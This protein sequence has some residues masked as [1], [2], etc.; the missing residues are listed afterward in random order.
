MSNVATGQTKETTSD[1]AGYYSMPNMLEGK[2]NLTVK[3]SGFRPHTETNIEVSI[4]TVT[5][6]N[7]GL[8][9]GGVT[10]SVTVEASAAILQT[11]KAD[12]NVSLESRAMENLPLSNFRNYQTLINLVPG[13]TPA[14]FQNA[15]ADTPGRS[16][17]TNIN[18]QQRGANNTRLDGSADILVTMPHH[19]V[20]V[21]PVESIAEV[22]ISTNS[23]DAEQGM[24]GGAAVTVVTKSGTNDFHGSLFA[25]HNNSATRAFLWDE[26]R[27]RVAKKPKN[28]LNIDGGSI[29]G[30]IKKNKLFFFADWEGTF[31]RS[32]RF[33]L[34]SVPTA[35]LRTGDFTRVFGDT[36]PMIFDPYTGI[37]DGSG[38][39]PFSYLGKFNVIPPAR[40]NG[41]MMQLL[42]LV[43][44]PNL[45]GDLDNYFVSGTQRLNRNNIDSKINWNRND[46]HQLWFKYSV[47]RATFGS[48]GFSL[49]KAG[50]ACLCDGGLGT[51]ATL[52]QVAAIG[53]T[54]TV[55]P[56]FL[57]DAT[58][59]WTRFGQAA[60]PPDQVSGINFGS[61]VLGIPGT[62]GPD[63][64]EAGMPAFEISGF[65]TLGNPEEWNPAFRNDQ[66]YTFNTN[67]NWIKGAHEIRFGFD[68][69]HHLM[70][71]WQPE[72]GRGPRGGFTFDTDVT[73]ISGSGGDEFNA[74]AAFLIGAPQNS[75]KSSQ[76][77][78][79]DSLEGQYALYVRDRWRVTPKL[80]LNLGL[81]WE[82][83]PNRRRSQ[84]LGIESYDPT[85]NEALIGGRVAFPEITA[86]AG[87]KSSLLPVSVSPIR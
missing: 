29:G 12:V 11:T 85:T 80:T 62:N 14:R 39:T 6:I 71:H 68:Y 10:E 82:L 58:L 21:P 81:R 74:L 19:A 53:Q 47:M 83:Y 65:S 75:G 9:V 45:P 60:Q 48:D 55:T 26:N 63:P 56:T 77:I 70:N 31:E 18:G 23:F 25:Y 51:T 3:A 41:P 59:G 15:E 8:Q 4:N 67:A 79:M 7:V 66:S 17:S 73:S 1:D 84:G 30:P 20:Y 27:A 49:G 22:N 33:R 78:K 46:K 44:Q 43:P 76:L 72:L 13:A 40:L 86:W 32:N 28:I 87:A 61:D 36:T 69:V 54:Y 34:A 52:T 5:R 42:D 16:L 64:R 50:G 24:T 57:I 37:Q 38:R 35:D 2:Y